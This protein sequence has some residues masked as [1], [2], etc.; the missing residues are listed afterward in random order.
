MT[1]FAHDSQVHFVRLSWDMWYPWAP[2]YQHYEKEPGVHVH[3]SPADAKAPAAAI[4]AGAASAGPAFARVFV[5]LGRVIGEMLLHVEPNS[6][7]SADI[8]MSA[9]GFQTGQAPACDP[10]VWLD[11]LWAPAAAALNALGADVSGPAAFGSRPVPKMASGKLLAVE[12]AEPASAP[13]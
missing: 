11:G 12:Q 1:M 2:P 9:H 13:A 5:A 3:L 6:D 8:F 10:N 4:S 7:G